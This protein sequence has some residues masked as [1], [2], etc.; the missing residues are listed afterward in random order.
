MQKQKQKQLEI[1]KITTSTKILWYTFLV[2]S[3]QCRAEMRRR[4]S[5]LVKETLRFRYPKSPLRP[6]FGGAR[7]LDNGG[8]KSWRSQIKN[9]INLPRIMFPIWEKSSRITCERERERGGRKKT[10]D[11]LFFTL[12]FYTSATHRTPR[13]SLLACF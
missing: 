5:D 2:E 7:W 4:L 6:G 12:I 11:R 9:R 3:E 1:K 13:H 8:S 10:R